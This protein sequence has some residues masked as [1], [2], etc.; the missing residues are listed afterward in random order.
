[1]EIKQA[2]FLTTVANDNILQNTKN[3]FAFVGRSNAGKSSLINA[4]T[5]NS[6]LAKTGQTAG[7]TKNIN[8]FLIN[9]GA[10]TFVDLPGY[11]FH[12]AGKQEEDKWAKTLENYFLNSK[13]L[14]CVFV[15]VDSRL[16]ASENDVNMLKFL[17]HYNIPF[18]VLAT[19]SDKLKKNDIQKNRQKVAYSLALGESNVIMCSSATKMGIREILSVMDNFVA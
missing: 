6:K 13:N 2:E 16:E 11:G 8:Y 15:L 18:M 5:K 3:E 1:M 7:L 19:K 14:K 12:K 9:K 10:F 4:L 17:S